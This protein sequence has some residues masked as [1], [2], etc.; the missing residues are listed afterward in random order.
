MDGRL[1]CSLLAA[2]AVAVVL[3]AVGCSSLKQDTSTNLPNATLPAS[4][5]QA[6]N[7]GWF[8]QKKPAY[9][10]PPGE[11]PQMRVAGAPKRDFKPETFSAFADAELEMAYDESARPDLDRDALLDVS[12]RKFQEALK[13]DPKNKTAMLGLAKLY[14]WAN[15]RDRAMQL[16]QD[17]IRSHPQDKDIPWACARSMVRFE[18]WT[19]AN[20]ACDQALAIDPE[21][22]TVMKAKGYFLARMNKWDDAFSSLL[23]VMP[24]SEARTFLGRTLVGLGR[25]QEGMQQLQL[26]VAKDPNNELAANLLAQVSDTGG[27]AAPTNTD[28]QQTGAVQR[29]PIQ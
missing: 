11:Q 4:A 9:G 27:G 24:E 15:D 26:A 29:Q 1:R 13:K 16:Y 19:G 12:R 20:K 25:K 28:L 8:S 17:A 18:D 21:N 2:V 5:Q 10:P 6:S 14:T 23:H 7:G 22:R 3:P